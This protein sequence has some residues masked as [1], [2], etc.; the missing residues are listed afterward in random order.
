MNEVEKFLDD[1]T[2]NS[3]YEFLD[4]AKH[5]DELTE[6]AKKRGIRLPAHDLAPFKCVYAMVNRFNKNG[7][8]LPKEEVEKALDTLNGKAIDFD[9]ARRRVIG[10]WIDAKIIKDEIHAYG[11]FFKGNFPDDY[12]NVKDLMSKGKVK[13]SF[14]SWGNKEFGKNG[15]YSLNDIEF[16][17]GGLL[18]ESEPAFSDTE[19]LEM[20]EEKKERILEFAKIMTP[21]KQFVHLASY[22]CECIQCG[23]KLTTEEH[24]RDVKCPKCG[25][26]MRRENRPGP[27][28]G[29]EDIEDSQYYS[30]EMESIRRALSQ[31]DCPTCGENGFSEIKMVDFA[32]NQAKVK[33]LNCQS[34]MSV[35]LT[36]SAKLTKKGKKIK[37]LTPMKAS[38][39]DFEK[40]ID[41]YGGSD[42]SLEI[43]IENSFEDAVKLKYEQRQNLQDNSFAVVKEVTTKSDKKR[44]IRMFPIQDPAHVRNALARLAQ[45]KVQETLSKLGIS[46]DTVKNKILRRARQ[47]KM[48]DLLERYKKGSVDEV[49]QEIAKVSITR[50]LSVEELEKAKT[51]V[52]AKGE[53]ISEDEVKAIIVSFKKEDKKDVVDE[54]AQ[55]KIVE[56]KDK[57]I[58]DLTEK[59]DTA[60]KKLTELETKLTEIEK[61]KVKE[62]VDARR[63]ELGEFAKDFTDEQILNEDKYEMAKLKKENAEL[64]AGGNSVNTGKK[65]DNQDP[66]LTKGSTDKDGEKRIE[67]A[68]K[69]VDELAFPR[70]K[71]EDTTEEE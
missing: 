18:L 2:H 59:L 13:V 52:D 65:D 19:I 10:H 47:L 27:G 69:K 45:T 48:K 24:C 50:E 57:E 32:N 14:E 70:K 68:A 56:A 4:E 37:K 63:K 35:D 41:D 23:H 28:Q 9:H 61:A 3:R 53:S 55:K 25:G 5:E 34:E 26:Q 71:K 7:C 38:V 44:K 21:P 33:C 6:I 46:I 42:E 8:K 15:K 40:F 39:E 11:I 58:K 16:A 1:F 66:D 36:P 54:D 62:L 43:A 20:A 29:D 22:N 30:Y 17:G 67:T 31:V 51:Q 49:L 60:S 64:K 12:I